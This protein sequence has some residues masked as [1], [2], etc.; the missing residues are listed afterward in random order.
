[1]VRILKTYASFTRNY[2][3]SRRFVDSSRLGCVHT[4]VGDRGEV[5]CV[6]A[7]PQVYTRAHC[8]E[9]ERLLP[10]NFAMNTRPCPARHWC[11]STY[12]SVEAVMAAFN[13][14]GEKVRSFLEELVC[15]HNPAK[16]GVCL[17]VNNQESMFSAE[18]IYQSFKDPDLVC[19]KS[20]CPPGK[21]PFL[22]P[23]GYHRCR[24]RIGRFSGNLGRPCKR[25]QIYRRGKCVSRFF[26]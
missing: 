25:N 22:D 8:G 6:E 10:V 2:E 4:A 19:K 20:P 26:G 9:G 24:N 15:S 11:R 14:S 18:N 1:M 16:R 7:G 23:D 17:P 5:R 13:R 3:I 21:E 12:P